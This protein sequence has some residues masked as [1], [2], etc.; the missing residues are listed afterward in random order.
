MQ[1]VLD[2][3]GKICKREGTCRKGKLFALTFRCHTTKL[4][5]VLLSVFL[6]KQS[7]I[8]SGGL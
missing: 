4:G 7:T 6:V 1:D 5:P 8:Y 3:K 2:K